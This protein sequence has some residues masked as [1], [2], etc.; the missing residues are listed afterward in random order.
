MK[1]T[2]FAVLFLGVAFALVAN[3]FLFPTKFKNGC[4]PNPCKHKSTCKLDAKNSSLSTCACPEGYHGKHCEL[5][6]GCYSK[7]CKKGNCTNNKINPSNY[8]C[9]CQAGI[10]GKNC[11]TA[12]ACLKNPCKGG[13]CDLDAKLKPVCS[14]N[15]GWGSK[16]C[17]KRII[18]SFF[19]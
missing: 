3:G 7:P 6:T 17:D 15:Y 11:D 12:D 2:L 19:N 14:C 13:R 5:K 4:D 16:N 9:T 8:T 18:D 10:V 1:S